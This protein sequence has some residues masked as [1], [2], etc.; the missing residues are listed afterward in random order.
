MGQVVEKLSCHVR[1][2]KSHRRHG[3]G[4]HRH[5]LL[6]AYQVKYSHRSSQLLSKLRARCPVLRVF[7]LVRTLGCV[8]S[9]I[10]CILY[11]QAQ[12]V[13][14]HQVSLRLLRSETEVHRRAEYFVRVQ[15]L[16]FVPKGCQSM[17]EW[18]DWWACAG[19]D[20]R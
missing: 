12:G 11:L 14:F 15:A 8:S 6:A 9:H 3:S 4:Q 16:T 20:Y 1:A 18:L 5:L 17:L 7:V 13:V 19:K 10:L 2:R